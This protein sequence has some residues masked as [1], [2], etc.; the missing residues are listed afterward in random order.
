ML[1]IDQWG[2]L[3]WTIIH[4]GLLIAT[5][6]FASALQSSFD[7]SA[8]LQLRLDATATPISSSLALPLL[9]WDTLHFIAMASPRPLPL[10]VSTSHAGHY[11][12]QA[13]GGTIQA[14]QSLAFQPG[15]VWLLRMSGYRDSNK[16][17][18]NPSQAVLLT[19]TLAA[20]LSCVLPLMLF[21]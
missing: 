18:W 3:R 10:P 8:W 4:R 17:T 2:I 14:E 5:L 12:R 21:R 6:F 19:S 15:I 7:S 1:T 20:I 16:M 11:P 13:K 9:R